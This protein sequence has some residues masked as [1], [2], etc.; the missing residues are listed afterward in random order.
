MQEIAEAAG[1]GRRTL[2]RH[3]DS[4]DV[5]IAEA[6]SSALDWYDVRV[7]KMAESDEPF[8]SWL[9]ELVSRIH[10]LHRSAGRGLWQLAASDDHDFGHEIAAV[11]RRRRTKRRAAT[12]DIADS[13]W[14]RAGGIGT[15]PAVVHDACALTISSFATHSMINDYGRD[16]QAVALCTAAMLGALIRTEVVARVRNSDRGKKRN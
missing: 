13:A 15:C 6:L 3:F 11:N 9:L 1:L 16:A 7:Q 4:R 2:F 14:R 8:E 5:L 12:G 10:D